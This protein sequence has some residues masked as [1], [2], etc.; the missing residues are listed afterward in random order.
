MIVP[1]G[2]H[3][4]NIESADQC[5]ALC[6]ARLNQLNQAI[7]QRQWKRSAQLAQDYSALLGQ[8]NQFE[9]SEGTANE[10][11]QLDIRHR[12]CIRKL[13]AQMARVS[14]D[15]ESLENGKKRIDHSRQTAE[16]LF[17]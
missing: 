10:L 4:V 6:L 11:I 2:G 7:Q 14:E 5:I 13:T 15:L 17:Q 16:A 3:R 1:G 9:S 8:I 12:R